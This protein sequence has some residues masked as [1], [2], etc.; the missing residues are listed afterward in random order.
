M[1]AHLLIFTT[2]ER[3]QTQC[4]AP[5][6]VSATVVEPTRQEDDMSE[7]GQGKFVVVDIRPV[8]SLLTFWPP[9]FSKFVGNINAAL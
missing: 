1:I 4:R 2:A 3:H 5:C 6:A 7:S 8:K 9:S